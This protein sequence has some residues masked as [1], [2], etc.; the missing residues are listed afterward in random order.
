M[1]L[2]K[3]LCLPP[4]GL[5]IAALVALGLRTWRP[6]LAHRLLVGCLAALYLV[7]TPLFSGLAL[8]SLQP[9]YVDPRSLGTAQAI[10]VLGGGTAGHAPEY[11]ADSVNYRT[12]VR[13][14]YAARLQRLTGL[15]VLVSGG[16]S[17]R[18]SSEAEQMRAVLAGEMGVPVRWLET[19]SVDT[20]TNALESAKILHGAGIRRIYL[21]T[22]AWHMPRARLAFEHAGFEVLPAGTGYASLDWSDVDI[23]DFLPHASGFLNGY[24]FFHE[25][26]GYAVYALRT[27]L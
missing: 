9:P 27:R 26:L 7:S 19:R 25:I 2:L 12:L 11:G 5:L 18:T 14:R 8:E 10:V 16:S 20:Y 3:A 17:G 1:N 24:Y 22:H 23:L 13:V 21:V 15:P 6:R 4:G